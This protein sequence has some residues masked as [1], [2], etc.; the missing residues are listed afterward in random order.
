[1]NYGQACATAMTS[2]SRLMF[3]VALFMSWMRHFRM[4]RKYQK[5]SPRAR[6]GLFLGFSE[7]HSSQVPLMLNVDTGKISPQFHVIF[8]DTFQTVHS[9]PSNKPIH[10]Q[11]EEI[12][13]FVREC[14]AEMDYDENG[15][16]IPPFLS[17][18]IKTSE[19]NA[20][21]GTCKTL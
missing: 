13:K 6:L 10:T 20:S 8:D 17:D 4:G 15:E 9:L 7:V 21:K 11:W 18:I 1:M 16:P 3:L 2:S 19:K 12:L 5:W 14:F